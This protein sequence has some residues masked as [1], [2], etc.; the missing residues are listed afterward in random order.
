MA[1][2]QSE[3][4]ASVL[5]LVEAELTGVFPR[6]E[7]LVE[8]TRAAT[9]G[10]MIQSEVDTILAADVKSLV[11]LQRN[12]ALDVFIDGQLNWQDLFRPFS[13]IF[14]GIHPGALTRW[15]DNNTFYRKPIVAD[16]IAFRGSGIGEFF[17]HDLLPTTARKAILPGPFTFAILSEN[18]AYQSL[19]DLTD[20]LA[21]ALRETV[22]NLQKAGYT[23]FQFN[24]PVLVG[25]AATKRDLEVAK[26]AF[27]VCAKGVTG[28]TTLQTY[29]GDAGPIIDELLDYPVDCIGLDF[30]ATSIS[31]LTAHDFNKQLG[32]GCIDG[33][34]SLLE[35]PG[36]LSKFVAEI[37]KRLNPKTVHLNP[38][39]DL[40]F[41]PETVAEKKVRLLG[42]TKAKL[43]K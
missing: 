9:R 31:S 33:R 35:T 14:T 28:Q 26:H 42:E 12:T 22:A 24:E 8:A 7:K 43:A 17:R 11:E 13:E 18:S 19:A 20:D 27:E 21:H 4:I 5:L 25:N 38:N 3:A 16:N 1:L 34:N 39:C 40:D 15:F 41:L 6:S 23:A 10:K 2:A 30:Y 36:D 32:C 29:F 37:G